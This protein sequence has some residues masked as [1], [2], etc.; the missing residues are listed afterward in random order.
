MFIS[1][2][3]ERAI[4]KHSSKSEEEFIYNF[5]INHQYKDLPRLKKSEKSY[6]KDTFDVQICKSIGLVW[7]TNDAITQLL[8]SIKNNEVP[9][10]PFVYESTQLNSTYFKILPVK[11]KF[12]LQIVANSIKLSQ[13]DYVKYYSILLG[14]CE[15]IR[16]KLKINV[17]LIWNVNIL[18][19]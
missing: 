11:K 1:T 9:E 7:Q 10:L 19:L 13:S 16:T 6:F 8:E 18:E 4:K 15:F 5:S 3:L 17:D 12:K 2:I 14:L